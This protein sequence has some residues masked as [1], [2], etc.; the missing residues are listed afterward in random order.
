MWL[1]QT[2]LPFGRAFFPILILAVSGFRSDPD[3]RVYVFKG[4]IFVAA[5]KDLTVSFPEHEYFQMIFSVSR[6]IML[7]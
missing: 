4:L 7:Q 5:F 3:L 2:D 6:F 1:V